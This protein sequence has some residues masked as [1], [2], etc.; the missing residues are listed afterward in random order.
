MCCENCADIF[1]VDGDLPE[2][3][4]GECPM[5]QLTPGAERLLEVWSLLKGLGD[6]VDRRSIHEMYG[7]TKRDLLSFAFIEDKIKEFKEALDG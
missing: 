4:T 5:P 7:V 1:N 2:C 3:E 6:F